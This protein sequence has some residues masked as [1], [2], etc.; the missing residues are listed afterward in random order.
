MIVGLSVGLIVGISQPQNASAQ[1]GAGPDLALPESADSALAAEPGSARLDAGATANRLGLDTDDPVNPIERPPVERLDDVTQDKRELEL[2][3]QDAAR[4]AAE[5]ERARQNAVNQQKQATTAAEHRLAGW[6]AELEN[7]RSLQARYEAKLIRIRT[8]IDARNIQIADLITRISAASP[9]RSAH[10]PRFRE[11]STALFDERTRGLNH[12]LHWKAPPPLVPRPKPRDSETIAILGRQAIARLDAQAA[13]LSEHADALE[14]EASTT[15]KLEFQNSYRQS[16][17]LTTTLIEALQASPSLK[18][19]LRSLN[20][21]TRHE[22]GGEAVH[23]ALRLGFWARTRLDQ[24]WQIP[25]NFTYGQ[26]AALLWT[27]FKLLVL[28]LVALWARRRWTHWMQWLIEEIG[29]TLTYG[30]FALFLVRLAESAKQFGPPVVVLAAALISYRVFSTLSPEVRLGLT[31]II[32]TTTLRAQLRLVESICHQL[33]RRQRERTRERELLAQDDRDSELEDRNSEDDN[34]GNS[35]NNQET[36][37]GNK[38]SPNNSNGNIEPFWQLFAKTWRHFTGYVAVFVILLIITNFIVGRGVFYGIAV[39]WAWLLAIP[40]TLLFLRTWRTW[41]VHELTVRSEGSGETFIGNLA[42]RHSH[43]LYGVVI[44]FGAFVVVVGRR[45]AA[46]I[47]DHFFGLNSTRR[48]LA[49]LFRRQVQKHAQQHGRVLDKQ[50]PLPESITR[51]FHD[52]GDDLG[53]LRQTVIVEIVEAHNNW[54]EN[55]TDGSVAIVGESGMGKTQLLGELPKVL[56]TANVSSIALNDKLSQPR[57]LYQWLSKSL[58]LGDSPKTEPLLISALRAGPRRIITIDHC[59]HLFLRKVGGFD[60]WRAFIRIVSECGSEVFWVLSFEKAAWDYLSNVGGRVEY[61]RKVIKMPEWSETDLRRL[62]L[63]RMRRSRYRVNFSDLLVTRLEGVKMKSQI[64]RTSQ[65]YFRLLWDYA[66]GNPTLA[67]FF[68]LRSLIPDPD[69]HSVRVHLFGA[70]RIEE[71]EKLSDDLAFVL[72]AVVEHASANA[73]ELAEITNISL[74]RCRF[75]LRLGRERGYLV[76]RGPRVVI[77][78][79]WYQTIRT[80]LKRKHLLYS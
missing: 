27:A 34:S 48:A 3:E 18:S 52:L 63:G 55:G 35:N 65:G 73:N 23:A 10:E 45:S 4:K 29:K 53:P 2:R 7:I 71:L 77:S 75:A 66:N 9:I 13:E 54:L 8:G 6:R 72:T 56:G 5:A 61:F 24:L 76:S 47:R 70:P 64:I 59:H 79:L 42:K 16:V 26:F 51:Q 62:I 28:L 33:W 30:Q 38:A 46:F 41:I 14:A 78:P 12:V 68:W 67:C 44:V 36:V 17:R 49:F 50:H 21:P 20:Q 40:L 15:A 11:L 80:Y 31:L 1:P 60:A 69:S 58:E 32:A 37:S 22:L 39:R 25:A 74:H 43:R 57:Q 19:E